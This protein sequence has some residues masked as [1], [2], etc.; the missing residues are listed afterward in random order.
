MADMRNDRYL[1][2]VLMT[3]HGMVRTF[4]SRDFGDVMSIGPLNASPGLCAWTE[5]RKHTGSDGFPELAPEIRTAPCL[6]LYV[7]SQR[8][9]GF[10][11]RIPD[12][13]GRPA[14]LRIGLPETGS[15][16]IGNPY[17]NLNSAVTRAIE[18]YTEKLCCEMIRIR[19]KGIVDYTVLCHEFDFHRRLLIDAWG[20][21]TI[22][23][24]PVYGLM[25][26]SNGVLFYRPVGII[27]RNIDLYNHDDG[28]SGNAVVGQGV[29]LCGGQS[30]SCIFNGVRGIA[31]LSD[32]GWNNFS[33]WGD[34]WNCQIHNAALL[35]SGNAES[36]AIRMAGGNGEGG[37]MYDAK[38]QIDMTTNEAVV[39]GIRAQDDAVIQHIQG[40]IRISRKTEMVR[41]G[42]DSSIVFLSGAQ[43][44]V[45]FRDCTLEA[46]AEAPCAVSSWHIEGGSK[47]SRFKFVGVSTGN[48][49]EAYG[50]TNLI[51]VDCNIDLFGAGNLDMRGIYCSHR[52]P[53]KFSINA[54]T[55]HFSLKGE[56]GRDTYTDRYYYTET[57]RW[58]MI[59]GTVYVYNSILNRFT[60][61]ITSVF[62][63]D[64]DPTPDGADWRNAYCTYGDAS[65]N[66]YY[67]CS[68][69]VAYCRA[70][71]AGHEP[72]DCETCRI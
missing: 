28:N 23:G 44:I 47:P 16:T 72:Y 71:T 6:D 35:V 30:R 59:Y 61:D 1:K 22:H 34:W 63:E 48:G 69:P 57:T 38:I 24:C 64:A 39:F 56:P 50:T 65:G 26:N 27:F 19:V 45:T 4:Q 43:R 42:I 49:S 32:G 37:M 3:R 13:N 12:F 5:L 62:I 53:E 41:K 66:V 40:T 9:M 29:S 51:D 21:E 7:D 20:D 67:E 14:T 18:C 17:I 46:E 33:L 52:L 54:Q 15:G 8:A 31:V 60:C 36:V 68:E 25:A 2:P 55:V 10:E 70:K 11:T 58:S